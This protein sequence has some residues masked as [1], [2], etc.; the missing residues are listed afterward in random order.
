MSTTFIISQC[1]VSGEISPQ[2]EEDMLQ[3]F[4]LFYLD[5]YFLIFRNHIKK[6]DFFL[7]VVM[8]SL[9]L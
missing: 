4:Y 1:V 8:R 6:V 2:I 3:Y 7:F 5:F 9:A